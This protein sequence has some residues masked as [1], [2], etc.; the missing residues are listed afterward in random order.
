VIG[1]IFYFGG[2]TST[3]EDKNRRNWSIFFLFKDNNLNTVTSS[4]CRWRF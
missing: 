3:V 2:R 4:E 1:V